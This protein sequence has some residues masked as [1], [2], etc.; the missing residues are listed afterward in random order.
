MDAEPTLVPAILFSDTVIREQGT[1]K[2]SIV[3]SFQFFNAVKFPFLSPPFV[4]TACFA[5]L[6]GPIDKLKVSVRIE[7]PNSG[8]VVFSAAA[9][10]GFAG[11]ILRPEVSYE[12][13]FGINPVQF[14]SPGV[15]SVVFLINNEVIGKRD[16]IVKS[17]TSNPT[18]Q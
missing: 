7:E 6:K 17:I 12:V 13:P 14:P 8:L 9:E 11:A 2:L 1:A 15:Y 3:G 16:L 5:N 10:V 4:V 18:P